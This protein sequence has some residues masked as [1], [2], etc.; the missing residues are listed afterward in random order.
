[1]LKTL[2]PL[3]LRYPGNHFMAKPLPL[4][5][6]SRARIRATAL[7]LLGSYV[8]AHLC[9]RMLP[10]V[11]DTWN[12]QT[13]D[14]LF[15]LRSSWDRFRPA[16]DERVVHVDFDEISTRELKSPYLNRTQLT[17]AVG[18]LASIGVAA[19]VYDFIIAAPINKQVDEA[20]VDAVKKAGNVYFGMAFK[21]LEKGVTKPKP[22]GHGEAARYLHETQWPVTVAGDPAEMYTGIGPRITFLLLASASRGLGSL[23]V[24][25]DRDGVLR[26]VP[27][28]VRYGDG[29]YPLL[30]FR[31]VCD[32]L[33][34][35]PEKITITPGRHILLK[36][37]RAPGESLAHDIAI[38]I[39]QKGNMVVNYVGAWDRM[40]HYRFDKILSARDD[41]D[42]LEILRGLLKGRIAVVSDNSLGSTDTGPVG[43]HRPQ[44]S[45]K[46]CPCQCDQQHFNG[47][48][49]AG[50]I[51]LGHVPHG[52]IPA[53]GDFRALL[54][55]S[56]SPVFL[57]R[58][59]GGHRVH[60]FCGY[61]F[62][63][64]GR[65]L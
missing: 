60:G 36:D 64:R 5:T 11:F 52:V 18:N 65:H 53:P 24:D 54:L 21:S 30:S 32:Y 37:A 29:F 1:M 14:Q 58:P 17:E 31:T 7:L 35:P 59:R 42:E 56:I 63:L 28:L 4:N 22:S 38:P 44:I 50:G 49:F 61:G 48:F 27:L 47:I 23:S 41:R 39:D 34:V 55:T 43:P 40:A 46:R 33:G 62:P 8:A 10:N 3:R 2:T 20:F 19:Q 25:L 57:E 16:Y 26:R 9:F 45:P 15:V 12:D 13:T 6:R 51:S